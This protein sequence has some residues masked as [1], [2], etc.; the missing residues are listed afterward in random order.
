MQYRAAGISGR[1][2]TLQV[3]S[4]AHLT[5]RHRRH[6]PEAGVTS[7]HHSRPLLA[8]MLG[9]GGG[10]LLLMAGILVAALVFTGY[11]ALTVLLFLPLVGLRMMFPRPIGGEAVARVGCRRANGGDAGVSRLRQEK[12]GRGRVMATAATTRRTLDRPR[13]VLTF[14]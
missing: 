9:L 13:F 11:V 10:R 8:T 12:N 3:D 1:F 5:V 14:Y 6:S 4:G 2:V 7:A